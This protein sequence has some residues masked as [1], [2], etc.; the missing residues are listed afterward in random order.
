MKMLLKIVLVISLL[1]TSANS[2]AEKITS[3]NCRL[4]NCSAASIALSNALDNFSGWFKPVNKKG[5][6]AAVIA[7]TAAVLTGGVAAIPA[8]ATAL[9]NS[10]TAME[11]VDKA[12]S[13]PAKKEK[14][15]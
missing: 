10:D 1:V 7:A 5:T 11:Y 9:S 8:L 13:E 2:V 14:D 6:D 4:E 12:T 15:K 3:Q